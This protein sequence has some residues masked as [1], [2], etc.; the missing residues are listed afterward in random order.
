M[1]A[2]APLAGLDRRQQFLL[3]L[4]RHGRAGLRIGAFARQI[5][6][7][8]ESEGVELVDV[9]VE[10]RAVL[11]ANHLES[12]LL[13]PLEHELFG[14]AQRVVLARNR[15]MLVARAAREIKHFLLRGAGGGQP[16]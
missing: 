14:N 7:R 2:Q 10:H 9:A 5:A 13:P 8:I 12:G 16:S 1:D 4:G 6:G 11:A 3:S 15:R